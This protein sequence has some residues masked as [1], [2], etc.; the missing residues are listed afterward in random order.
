MSISNKY[1]DTLEDLVDSLD[2]EHPAIPKQI[3][4]PS[5]DIPGF[6]NDP[7]NPK[8]DDDPLNR[9]QGQQQCQITPPP[10]L[11]PKSS[12]ERVKGGKSKRDNGEHRGGRREVIRRGGG[13]LE[14]SVD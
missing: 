9:V 11:G 2:I 3:D 8:I 13:I 14:V 6:K 12:D 10:I 4:L 5:N 1:K 7:S